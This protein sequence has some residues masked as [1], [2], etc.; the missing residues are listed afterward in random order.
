MSSSIGKNFSSFKGP[1]DLNSRFHDFLKKEV[2]KSKSSIKSTDKLRVFSKGIKLQLL[3]ILMEFKQ[4]F[5]EK[6]TVRGEFNEL[7]KQL[8]GDM[9][10]ASFKQLVDACLNHIAKKSASKDVKQQKI[11]FLDSVLVKLD[12]NKDEFCKF[13][14]LPITDF[15]KGKKLLISTEVMLGKKAPKINKIFKSGIDD[16]QEVFTSLNDL[17]DKDESLSEVDALMEE[18]QRSL[19][20][21]L[22][23][24]LGVERPLPSNSVLTESK[25][26]EKF[27]GSSYSLGRISDAQLSDDQLSDMEELEAYFD[28][29][30]DLTYEQQSFIAEINTL[31]PEQLKGL[32]QRLIADS[33]QMANAFDEFIAPLE[34]PEYKDM[35]IMNAEQLDVYNK[36]HEAYDKVYWE[37]Q[38]KYCNATKITF[39]KPPEVTEKELDE[40]LAKLNAQYLGFS[41]AE[42][43]VSESSFQSGTTSS[44]GHT[45]DEFSSSSSSS[46]VSSL[47]SKDQKSKNIYDEISGLIELNLK[48]FNVIN[49]DLSQMETSFKSYVT[50]YNELLTTPKVKKDVRH[51]NRLHMHKQRFANLKTSLHNLWIIQKRVLGKNII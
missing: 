8:I 4:G 10:E 5:E 38:E 25:L 31:T 35:T 21:D 48:L 40:E 16:A 49:Q 41:N 23:R 11:K 39:E 33:L 43:V 2:L 12:L 27:G 26:A 20:F 45:T 17:L 47:D 24:P 42:D 37:A 6:C 14:R 13:R 1:G 29:L 44:S 36:E 51:M 32:E 46:S 22:S 15:L 28:S 3:D 34:E 18:A 30:P 9:F 7:S 50:D 19:G